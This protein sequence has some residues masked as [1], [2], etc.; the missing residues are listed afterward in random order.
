M[1]EETQD[2]LPPTLGIDVGEEVQNEDGLTN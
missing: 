1:D 2:D